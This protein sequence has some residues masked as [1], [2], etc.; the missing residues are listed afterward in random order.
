MIAGGLGGSFP[1][2]HRARLFPLP[3]L[4]SACKPPSR[5]SRVHQRHRLYQ[6]IAA[7]SN[8][9]IHTLNCM[10]SSP[11]L[12]PLPPPPVFTGH[13][14]DTFSSSV[15]LRSL[16]H[17]VGV[18]WS[19]SQQ[20]LLT[21]IR[22]QCATFVLSLRSW[23][24]L[25]SGSVAGPSVSD[26]LTSFSSV[27]HQSLTD[28]RAASPL[29]NDLSSSSFSST[30]SAEFS[31]LEGPLPVVDWSSVPLPS[32]S[33]FSSSPTSV[34][35]LIADR[36]ALPDSLHIVPLESVLPSDVVT[37]YSQAAS[38]SLL[39]PPVEVMGLDAAYPLRRPRVAGSRAEYVR[40]IGRLRSQGMVSFTPT[41]KAVNGVFAVGKDADSDRLIIDAQPANRLFVDPP[42]V[43]LPD[44]SHL[45]QLQVP[46]GATMFVGK[47]DLSNFYHHIGLP[48]W[49]Q[50]YFS[51]PPLT[52]VELRSIGVDAACDELHPMCVTLPMGF[53]HA[54]YLA[55]TVHEHVV[56]S[57]GALSAAD[58]IVRMVSPAV[59]A[60]RALHGIVIDDFFLFSLNQQLATRQFE[61]VLAAY[62]RAGFVVKASKVVRPTA[63]PVK[64]IGFEVGGPT[65]VVCLS[66]ESRFALIRATLAVLRVGQLTGTALAH[67][68]GRWT[69]CMLVRRPAL[70]VLQRVYR[71]VEAA[72]SRRFDLWPSVRRELWMLLGLLP[73]LHARLDAPLFHRAVTSDASELAAGVV[74]TPLTP[75]LR[76]R[77]WPLCST[78]CHAVLQTQM[79]SDSPANLLYSSR[80]LLSAA[81]RAELSIAE[82]VFRSFY[83]D[84]SD[85]PWSTIVSKA[86]RDP[87]HINALE[88]RAVLLAVHWVLSFPSS[89]TRRVFLLVDSTVAFFS[90]WKGRSSSPQLLLI[91]RK[92]G[93]LLLASG[94]TLLPGWVPS[95][96]N[97][98]DNPSRLRP[99][100]YPSW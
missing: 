24:S 31:S 12:S 10:Y 85:A 82:E 65:S 52:A 81:Q 44:P 74:A 99:M 35:P 55:E 88:L 28:N 93:A 71:F 80:L 100:D 42:H 87:E 70:S 63:E 77:L 90:L 72:R 33:S 49:M 29:P 45:V 32:M 22:D 21:H 60:A 57:S 6:T 11:A 48:L 78:R 56:Y 3:F 7:V 69:W 51:L 58:S 16:R 84:V 27:A 73:L 50:P 61:C 97:P 36:V 17:S 2:S 40:L 8:R 18:G 79:Q 62:R 98:A 43:S 91:L 41:P 54:V 9:C 30:A 26:V 75:V 15:S 94:V 92:I 67:L 96:V 14:P 83:D 66:T 46:V 95:E 53:S 25:G 47:S 20:R 76:Q 59:T 4:P 89:L 23:R 19:S 38:C 64:V 34:V 39:R 13:Q 1:L 86:W 37:S 68:V 5:S